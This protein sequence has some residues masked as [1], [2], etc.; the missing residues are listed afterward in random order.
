MDWTSKNQALQ[1]WQN[2]FYFYFKWSTVGYLLKNIYQHDSLC[3]SFSLFSLS[4]SLKIRPE[5]VISQALLQI[6]NVS[7]LRRA[8]WFSVEQVLKVKKKLIYGRLH[9]FINHWKVG[10]PDLLKGPV[11][12]SLFTLCIHLNSWIWL[13]QFSSKHG[14][15][16]YIK[17][18]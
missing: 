3:L 11:R 18:T 15:I 6:Y 4:P 16:L 10:I 2:H 1:Y 12:M 7:V 14:H 5:H 8:D 9:L 17:L 13:V